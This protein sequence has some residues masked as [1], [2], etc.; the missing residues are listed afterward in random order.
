[1]AAHAAV[2]A[3][4]KPG[5]DNGWPRSGNPDCWPGAGR[6][7]VIIGPHRFHPSRV[8]APLSGY[9]GRCGVGHRG[10]R[11]AR[12]PSSFLQPLRDRCLWV[13]WEAQEERF[14]RM[15]TQ[16]ADKPGGSSPRGASFALP[17]APSRSHPGSVDRASFCGRG[18]CARRGRGLAADLIHR[19]PRLG[20]G[21]VWRGESN[22][23]R[24]VP[25]AS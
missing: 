12:P 23:C 10:C 6:W 1:M 20:W 22:R 3:A 16:R 2:S 5:A 4:A 19:P 17:S 21:L 13:S 15:N 11:F 18:G 7:W 9:T 24:A 14:S 25:P 8:H